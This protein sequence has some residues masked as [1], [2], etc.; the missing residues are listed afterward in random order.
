MIVAVLGASLISIMT[1]EVA[2][3]YVALLNGD[4]T[5][6]NMGRLSFNPRVHFNLAG[7]VL[8][9]VAGI[10]WANPVPINPAAF[11]HVKR[12]ILTVSLAGVAANLLLAVAFFGCIGLVLLIPAEA[13]VKS[14]VVEVIFQLLLN[15][16]VFGTVINVALIAFNLLPIYPLD[17]FRV[18][19]CFAPQSGYARIM[20]K[21]GIY[22][23]IG[24]IVVGALLGRISRYLDP[25]GLYMDQILG[26]VQR[27]ISAAW[28]V[29]WI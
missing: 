6:K 18:V 1:H 9:L 23:L 10:G 24:I 26:F 22:I 8:F 29:Q 3:G 11:R 4:S 20:R 5:A 21:Y 25:F 17:G 13:I 15:F 27:L 14:V 12:G 19:E 28:G 2:H 16:F 7:M